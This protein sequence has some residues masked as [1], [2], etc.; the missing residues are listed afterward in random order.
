MKYRI[1][2]KQ[3]QTFLHTIYEN[4]DKNDIYSNDKL[5][6]E[7][8][9][10]TEELFS[11]LQKVL[12]SDKQTFNI[13]FNYYIDHIKDFY[14]K[15]FKNYTDKLNF[16]DN[17]QKEILNTVF[18]D[19][20]HVAHCIV[21]HL[22][23]K[24]NFQNP[25]SKII[26][27]IENLFFSKDF[28]KILNKNNKYDDK[29]NQFYNLFNYIST[30]VLPNI[31][32]EIA[33]R[34]YLFIKSGQFEKNIDKIIE[35]SEKYGNKK[36]EF[37]DE[38]VYLMKTCETP[39]KI[40]KVKGENIND[41]LNNGLVTC[42]KR[43]YPQTFME[44]TNRGAPAGYVDAVFEDDKGTLHVAL[45]TAQVLFKQTQEYFDNKSKF[46]IALKNYCS[47]HK[48]DIIF[49]DFQDSFQTKNLLLN[50]IMNTA[51]NSLSY[52]D[53]DNVMIY[54]LG[55]KKYQQLD[56]VSIYLSIENIL[57]RILDNDSP[58]LDDS[59][60]VLTKLLTY[61]N[62]NIEKD[63]NF[64]LD[65]DLIDSLSDSIEVIA[66]LKKNSES[67]DPLVILIKDI[68]SKVNNYSDKIQKEIDKQDELKKERNILIIKTSSIDNYLDTK[69]E[70]KLNNFKKEA[71]KELSILLD[72]IQELETSIRSN[73]KENLKRFLRHNAY[74]NSTYGE[75]T[76]IGISGL[77]HP[78]SLTGSNRFTDFC[79]DTPNDLII[80]TEAILSSLSQNPIYHSL[81]DFYTKN[82]LEQYAKSQKV[83]DVKEKSI[84][85]TDLSY[86]KIKDAIN[87]TISVIENI[88]L[89]GKNN[90]LSNVISVM[91]PDQLKDYPRFDR[92]VDQLF[93]NK[94][95]EKILSNLT[96]IKDKFTNELENDISNLEELRQNDLKRIKEIN[97]QINN[98]NRFKIKRFN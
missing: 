11:G 42:Q 83:I 69:V 5:N 18:S 24:N 9:E 17:N 62:K 12:I 26:E 63:F 91:L 65:N 51:T 78:I 59:F 36:N 96:K 71:T 29:E 66:D 2:E 40:K 79:I 33:S 90:N 45:T 98:G 86:L 95:F 16:L 47:I 82:P 61:I 34:F 25:T 97:S 3:L 44:Q 70:N 30:A 14:E 77:K 84:Y 68:I 23:K 19:E 57:D 92:K 22:F 58:S 54:C 85:E 13:L 74:I 80:H 27:N 87:N 89:E 35:I 4:Q 28:K 10:K 37:T 21:D 31:S 15:D 49:Y 7:I 6:N 52:N 56:K 64:L 43:L 73:S 8:S 41:E 67:Q 60:N 55:G 1:L 48:K 20:N 32:Y 94:T 93:E 53:T 39:L 46:V 50:R 38:L 88:I 76:K 81:E 72:T 75:P